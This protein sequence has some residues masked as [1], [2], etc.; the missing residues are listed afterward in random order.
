MELLVLGC[1]GTYPGANGATSGYLLDWGREGRLL[2]DCG[3]GVLPRLMARMDPANLKAVLLSHWHND[4]AADLLTLRYY[5]MVHQRSLPLYGPLEGGAMRSLCE[6]PELKL[7]D[8]SQGLADGPLQ[9]SALA[10]QHPVQTYALRFQCEDKV[11]VYTGDSAPH[12]PLAAFCQDADLLICDASC[13]Q[14]DWHP[15]F[16]HMSARQAAEL[17]GDAG[18][19]EL[20]LTHCPPHVDAMSLLAEARASFPN[21]QLAKA[22]TWYR[23]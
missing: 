12:Q 6:G 15:G 21:T 9:V 13:L 1:D 2:I 14:D 19:R 18:V 22:G 4:H 17:A 23:L 8:M 11:L 20:L 3:A 7:H 5:L 16:P 10:T